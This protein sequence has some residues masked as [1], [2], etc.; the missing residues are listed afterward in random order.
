ME[1]QVLKFVNKSNNQNP[2]YVD[3]ASSGFDLR[4]YITSENGGEYDIITQDYMITLKPF[5]RRMFHTGLYFDVPE[6]TEIQVRP[7]SGMSIK[8]GITVINTPGTVDENYTGEVC[9]LIINLSNEDVVITNGERIAQAVLMPVFNARSVKL[10]IVDEIV[11]E[12]ERGDGG[13][14]HTGT[15]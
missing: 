10:E 8:K 15:N 11:K 14:G 1:K 12:T 5:E 7:R 4:A 9:I 2:A 3:N 6:N 13:F